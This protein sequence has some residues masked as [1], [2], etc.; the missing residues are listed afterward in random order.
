MLT[1]VTL[2]IIVYY[3][4]YSKEESVSNY[5]NRKHTVDYSH[6]NIVYYNIYSKEESVSN[7]LNR[8]H[9]VG[10][11]HHNGGYYNNI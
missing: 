9:N 11:S 10:Y 6:H 3:N 5:L 4:I 2:I 7:Y 8:K 1:I